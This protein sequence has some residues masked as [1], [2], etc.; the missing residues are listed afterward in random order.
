MHLHPEHF[1]QDLFSLTFLLYYAIVAV[2]LIIIESLQTLWLVVGSK[3]DCPNR[4]LGSAL[5]AL[6]A[7]IYVSFGES[8]EKFRTARSTC[9]IGD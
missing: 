2:R 3:A 1:I 5:H 6:L 7:R 4:D 9:A 8:H